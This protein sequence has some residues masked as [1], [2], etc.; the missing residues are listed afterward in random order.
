MRPIKFRALAFKNEFVYGC[1]VTDGKKYHAI[2][3]PNPDDENEM[4]NRHVND[5]TVGQFTGT[6]DSYSQEMYK[7]D[8]VDVE[9]HGKCL[10][11]ICPYY[12]VVFIDSEGNEN[13]M[14]DCMAEDDSFKVIGNKHQSPELME[15][16]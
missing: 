1:Y 13:P 5:A 15:S 11:G 7:N 8:I 4:I 16:K 2:N 6:F 9:G 3:Y 10:V 14:I 12:G